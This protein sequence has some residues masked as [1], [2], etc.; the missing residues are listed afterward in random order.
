[1]EPVDFESLFKKFSSIKIGVVGD[2]MLDTYWWGHVERISPEAPV[3][4]VSLDRR[5][6]RIGGAGNVALNLSSLE[7][8]VTVFSV[9]GN[10]DDGKVLKSLLDQSFVNT[11]SLLT[12]DTRITTN[13]IRIIG[14]SQQMMRLDSETIKDLSA[15]DEHRIIQALSNY[16]E[17]EKPAILIF[18]DYNKGVLTERVIDELIGLCRK[19]NVL[20]AVDPKTRNFFSYK[21]V[22][23][24]K[25]NLKEVR[26]GLN[27]PVQQP[28]HYRQRLS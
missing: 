23:I 10:D 9:I 27:L 20:T 4:V 8:R 1:M 7:A 25:P 19:H 17:Q 5:E 24:F 11:D 14:R 22:D 28:D 2:V 18:E 6:Y 3:P 26:E 12:S 16:L 13:K 15:D 21:G